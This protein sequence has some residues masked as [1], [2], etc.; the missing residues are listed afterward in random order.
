MSCQVRAAKPDAAIFQAAAELAGVPPEEI[1][2]TDDLA[3]HVAGAREA[4]FDAVQYTSTPRLV[5]ELRDRGLR[6]NY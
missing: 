3:E 1:F 5:A 6:F 4:G 2:F